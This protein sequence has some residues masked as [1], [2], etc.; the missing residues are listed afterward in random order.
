MHNFTPAAEG[1]TIVFGA[2]RPG[3]SSK[4]VPNTEIDG[5]IEYMKQQG[6]KRVC[7]LLPPDQLEFYEGNLLDR[8]QEVFGESNVCHAPVDDYQLSAREDLWETIIPFLESSEAA[9]EPVVVHCSGGSGRTGHVLAAWLA[10]SR[11]IPPSE[12]ISL[13]E[14][15]GRNPME[16][17]ESENATKAEL[18]ELLD[19]EEHDDA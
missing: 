9:G 13:V 18:L 15:H 7:C 5:W 8:Y 2:R 11:G 4:A 3:Y 17:V 10:K 6:I 1:E 12:A 19:P 14:A 16:A